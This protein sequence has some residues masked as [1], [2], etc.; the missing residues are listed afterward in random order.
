MDQIIKFLEL[1]GLEYKN[2]SWENDKCIVTI[3]DDHYHLTFKD[4]LEWNMFSNDLNIYWLVGVLTWY[5]LIDK[6]F[7]F[8]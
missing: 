7:K 4:S 5:D 1:N 2:G 8:P 6:N 3:Q